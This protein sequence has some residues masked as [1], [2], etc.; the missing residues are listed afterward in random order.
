MIAAIF[1]HP[2]TLP[3]AAQLWLMLP[4][5]AAVAVVYKA[6]RVRQVRRLHIDVLAL[7][8]YMVLGLAALGAAL[9]AVHAYWP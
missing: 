9:W 5:C 2:I 6:V 4:L 1:T 7:M 3:A 8:L